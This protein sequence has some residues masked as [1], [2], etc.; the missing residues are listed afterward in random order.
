MG[1]S[2]SQRRTKFTH[3]GEPAEVL[4]GVRVQSHDDDVGLTRVR[5]RVPEG[6]REALAG[7]D[8]RRLAEHADG[9]GGRLCVEI[10]VCAC[11]LCE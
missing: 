7:G 3:L 2:S 11:A 10:D 6:E 8:A 4:L 9:V 1:G 5:L